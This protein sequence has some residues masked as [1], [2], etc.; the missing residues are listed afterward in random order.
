M[1]VS[2]HGPAERVRMPAA[3]HQ[4]VHDLGAGAEG[5]EAVACG[6]LRDDAVVVPAVVGQLAV[7]VQLVQDNGK[8]PHVAEEVDVAVLLKDFDG[9]PSDRELK[10]VTDWKKKEKKKK[11]EKKK[12]K[13]SDGN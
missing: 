13:G 1:D 7:A 5:E 9:T 10:N 4:V 2:Q 3:H 12:R 11:R 8:A 6:E